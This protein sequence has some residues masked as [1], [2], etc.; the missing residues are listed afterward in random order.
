MNALTALLGEGDER[1]TLDRAAL[2]LARIEFPHLELEPTLEEID[3]LAWRI[4]ERLTGGAD[5][6]HYLAAANQ[7]LFDE[8]GF[9]GNE[10]DY[11]DPLNSCLNEVV[12]RRTGIPISLSVLYMEIARRLGR[13]VHGIGL[14]GHFLVEFHTGLFSVYV[15]V[16]HQGRIL[17]KAECEE[18][19]QRVAGVALPPDSAVFQPA[20]RRQI[21]LR[22]LNNLR[23][24][25]FERR[26][27]PKALQVL[28]WLLVADPESASEYRQ[29][30]VIQLEMKNFRAA[31]R[32]LERYLGFAGETE[33]RALVEAQILR[34]K[35][36]EASLN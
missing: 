35:R 27:W 20:T 32:D 36:M 14:P 6:E 31:R 5:D 2:E 28:D 1:T 23:A 10:E 11:Y 16:F 15:D 12:R 17:S 30:A 13:T 7:L 24:I 34:L 19:A 25:Y 18:M 29:R 4:G 8:L 22:M 21:V 26:I 3:R 33:D 9:R